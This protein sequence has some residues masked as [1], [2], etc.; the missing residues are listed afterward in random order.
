MTGV[1]ADR[2]LETDCMSTWC[3]GRDHVN[4]LFLQLVSTSAFPN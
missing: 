2:S 4:P 3:M 1:Y